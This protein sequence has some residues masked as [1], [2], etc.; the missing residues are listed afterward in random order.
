MDRT[1]VSFSTQRANAPVTSTPSSWKRTPVIE[2]VAKKQPRICFQ[3]S[4]PFVY[5]TL[6]DA[7]MMYST[8]IRDAR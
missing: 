8:C 5:S 6:F 2:N 1:I 3:H 7:W 4:I